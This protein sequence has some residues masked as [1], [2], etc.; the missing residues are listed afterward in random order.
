MS[1]AISFYLRCP[2]SRPLPRKLPWLL[3][4]DVTLPLILILQIAQS[5][6]LR[7][8]FCNFCLVL[9]GVRWPKVRYVL[10]WASAGLSTPQAWLIFYRAKTVLSLQLWEKP[11]AS[12]SSSTQFLGPRL[13]DRQSAAKSFANRLWSSSSTF[14]K[15]WVGIFMFKKFRTRLSSHHFSLQNFLDI[16][17]Y[18]YFSEGILQRFLVSTTHLGTYLMLHYHLCYLS[19]PRFSYFLPLKCKLFT[20]GGLIVFSVDL[21]V[22]LPIGPCSKTMR[23]GLCSWL[24]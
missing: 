10:L 20:D 6:W 13:C 7:P 5:T 9:W 11:G 14:L 2:A 17:I 21:P 16:N 22:P 19:V 4:Q 3:Q 12:T 24:F 1:K 15:T 8:R 18:C 23:S